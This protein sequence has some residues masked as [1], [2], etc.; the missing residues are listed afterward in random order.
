M[1]NNATTTY[2]SVAGEAIYPHL[3]KPD[4]RFNEAGEYKVTLKVA[5]SDAS[6]MLKVFDQAIDDSLAI[7]KEETKG[8]DVKL[9]PKPYTIEG[10]NVFFKFKMKATGK[11]KKTNEPFSQRPMLFDAKKNPIPQS[12]SIWGGS[13][14]K[15]AYQLRPYFSPML[16]AGIVCQLKAV[17]ILELVEGK[18]L[19][20]FDEEDGFEVKEKEN[21]QETEVQTSADF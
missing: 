13:K 15:I 1:S 2:I 5:K 4:V 21:A 19:N 20:L 10:D 3:N 17:Q 9:A 7:A 18:Q 14:M 16:G 11:N 12:T 6:K 8:K